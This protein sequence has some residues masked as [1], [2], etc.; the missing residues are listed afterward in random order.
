MPV[1]HVVKLRQYHTSHSTSCCLRTTPC[2][3]PVP[4][5]AQHH[6]HHIPCQYSTMCR[7]LPPRT[8]TTPARA[9]RARDAS[10]A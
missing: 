8:A 2:A 7:Y 3:M 1:P 4:H 10:P 5:I 9:A 6:T